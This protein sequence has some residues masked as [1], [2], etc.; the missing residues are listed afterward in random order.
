MPATL[1]L[2]TPLQTQH[3][4]SLAA[5]LWLRNAPEIL[6][7]QN[8]QAMC[9]VERKSFRIIAAN[10]AA[11][12][13]YGYR[14][15]EFLS[16][17]L[18]DLCDVTE[19]ERLFALNTGSSRRHE[20][21]GC[22]K[23][24]RKDG[25]I[26]RVRAAWTSDLASRDAM[27]WTLEDRTPLDR[28][29]AAA[30]EAG[31]A[32]SGLV[33]HAPHGLCRFRLRNGAVEY[34]NS[35]MLALSGFNGT[36]EAALYQP[37]ALEKCFA[38]PAEADAFIAAMKSPE[39]F[40]Q[41]AQWRDAGPSLRSVSIYG[42]PMAADAVDRMIQFKDITAEQATAQT[43]EQRDKMESLG[44][45][46][47]TV[48]HDFNNILLVMRGY[49]EMLK[50][51]LPPSSTEGRHAA[52]LLAAAD[53]AAEVTSELVGFTRKD[54]HIWEML[55]LNQLAREL[56][57]SLFPTLPD[58][59]TGRLVLSDERLATGAERSQMQRM[60][61]NLAANARDAMP[62][63]GRLTIAT[64]A[65]AGSMAETREC[66][67][68]IRDTGTGMDEAT[69]MRIF[70]RF[71]TTK[72]AGRGTGLGL[73]FVESCMTQI[74]GRVEVESELGAGSCFRLVFV[75]EA[76]DVE[77]TEIA[78][79][80]E[81]ADAPDETAPASEQRG[82]QILLVDDDEHIQSLVA[83]V[84]KMLGYEVMIA[85]DATAALRV[86]N[87]PTQRIDL[88]L[89]D[90]TMPGTSG[91]VLAARVRQQLPLLPILLMSGRT[92]ISQFVN[93]GF[94]M[95]SKPF[96]ISEIKKQVEL[97]LQTDVSPK[98]SQYVQKVRR[99]HL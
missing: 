19:H 8:P 52:A 36:N 18:F 93:D 4:D 89:T 39:A 32:F 84:L 98:L 23:H 73:A 40:H 33:E 28:A 69:R 38:R 96:N 11:S 86:L 17:T 81:D 41:N 56:A 9:V 25:G 20:N 34:A 47:A 22:W 51:M 44:Q 82:L 72:G 57:V 68:E 62:G 27:L 64:C 35:I 74:G 88:L 29:Q 80:T 21:R 30:L 14:R 76:L 87:D 45:V 67:V 83:N 99:F 26:F 70:E 15:G 55:D 60:L 31:R 3:G 90:V 7:E 59:I 10:F 95:I 79:D 5:P 50:R 46:A 49:A 43:N 54:E 63:G 1:T 71:F 2:L 24:L 85:G 61:L 37:Q 6:F 12:A 42:Y 48:A 92:E 97:A 75:R 94:M 66:C 91:D 13:L 65:R 53:S 77:A 78:N 16:L 58:G